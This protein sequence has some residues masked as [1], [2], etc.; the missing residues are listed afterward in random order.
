M[1]LLQESSEKD[2]V[3]A[4]VLVVVVVERDKEV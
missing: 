4:R 1:S 3:R 2:L